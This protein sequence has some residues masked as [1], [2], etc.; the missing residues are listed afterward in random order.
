MI[1]NA[2]D[3]WPEDDWRGEAWPNFGAVFTERFGET[4][5]LFF[6]LKSYLF[7]RG[8]YEGDEQATLAKWIL[9]YGCYCQ[10][11]NDQYSSFVIGL[12]N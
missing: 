1:W 3:A 10:L 9:S 7:F 11:R 2:D 4:R 12:K 6:F 8:G 5:Q